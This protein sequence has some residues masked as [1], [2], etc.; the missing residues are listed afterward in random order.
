MPLMTCKINGRSGWKWGQ[1]GKCYTGPRAK[2]K[3]ILQGVA[4]G[5]GK[6]RHDAV[7]PENPFVTYLKA[8]GLTL[9]KIRSRLR[10]RGPVRPTPRTVERKYE[11]KLKRLVAEWRTLYL[12]TVDPHLEG[13]A[14]EAYALKPPQSVGV[15]TD[16]W[17][18]K[19][20]LIAKDYERQIAATLAPVESVALR[21][22]TTYR[23][24]TL[25]N[26]NKRSRGWSG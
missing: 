17:P 2:K 16:A 19:L 20:D 5:G 4:A 13:L 23:T 11:I 24:L 6:L 26:G 21:R 14:Q 25:N 15:K 18:E 3:A 10:R 7:K 8:L 1:G 22:G 12:Q 9:P